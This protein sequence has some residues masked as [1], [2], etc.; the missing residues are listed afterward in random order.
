[1]AMSRLASLRFKVNQL[2]LRTLCVWSYANTVGLLFTT[3]AWIVNVTFCNV[4]DSKGS[5]IQLYV[6]L[7]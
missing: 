3:N 5:M 1:M 4:R 7:Y 6:E 2:F